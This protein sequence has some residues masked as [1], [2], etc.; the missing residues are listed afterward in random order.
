MR[1]TKSPMLSLGLHL[2][3]SSQSVRR[4]HPA[5]SEAAAGTTNAR[6]F[7]VT[8]EESDDGLQRLYRCEPVIVITVPRWAG[9]SESPNWAEQRTPWMMCEF[10]Y[11]QCDVFHKKTSISRTNLPKPGQNG[12]CILLISESSGDRCLQQTETSV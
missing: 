12:V 5:V 9:L 6:T 1:S 3:I 11:S 4:K 10:P 2:A 7:S 8:H